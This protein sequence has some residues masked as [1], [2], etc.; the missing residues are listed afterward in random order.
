MQFWERQLELR[1]I[2]GV[3]QKLSKIHEGDPKK[4][5]LKIRETESQMSIF[6]HQTKLPLQGLSC[7]LLHWWQ[8]DAI[9]ISQ[10]LRI[11]RQQVTLWKLNLGPL[12]EENTNKRHWTWRNCAGATENF[13]PYILVS[14]DEGWGWW[15]KTAGCLFLRK[16]HSYTGRLLWARPP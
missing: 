11:P 12:A 14:L 15:S 5:I 3:V 1:D 16:S 2:S 6:C 13:H 7:I 8:G 10:N 9:E 4:G